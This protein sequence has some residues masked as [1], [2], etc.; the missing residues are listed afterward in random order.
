MANFRGESIYVPLPKRGPRAQSGRANP[1]LYLSRLL[2]RECRSA[3]FIC[4]AK[5]TESFCTCQHSLVR[6]LQTE[7]YGERFWHEALH[8]CPW[9]KSRRVRILRPQIKVTGFRRGSPI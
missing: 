6:S 2:T 4:H 7:K 3:S 5:A 9:K 8:C 1:P